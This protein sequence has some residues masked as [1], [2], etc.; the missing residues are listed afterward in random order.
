MLPTG[1]NSDKLTFFVLR[2]F[3]RNHEG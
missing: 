2:C 1:K 3:V